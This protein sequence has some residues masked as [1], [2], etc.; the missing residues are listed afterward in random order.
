M[1]TSRYVAFAPA[2]VWLVEHPG[3]VGATREAACRPGEAFAD[4]VL[5]DPARLL[6]LYRVQVIESLAPG[7]RAGVT[8]QLIRVVRY[9]SARAG[10]PN[11]PAM[12]CCR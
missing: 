10:E 11:G 7:T 4:A 8:E 3:V 1:E 5:A 12:R 6:D 2:L 9:V